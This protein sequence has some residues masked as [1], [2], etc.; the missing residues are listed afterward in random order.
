MTDGERQ[1]WAGLATRLATSLPPGFLA[2][3]GIN[4]VLLGLLFWFLDRQIDSR[5]ALVGKL[6]DVCSERMK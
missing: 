6:I 1:T 3:F 5:L 2:V 4:L